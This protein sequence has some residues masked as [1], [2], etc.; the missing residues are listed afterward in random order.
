M[1]IQLSK[2]VGNIVQM[3]SLIQISNPTNPIPMALP[4]VGEPRRGPK[5]VLVQMVMGNFMFPIQSHEFSRE[6][7]EVERERDVN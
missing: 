1:F 4:Q 5:W 7:M 6:K 3:M 2:S